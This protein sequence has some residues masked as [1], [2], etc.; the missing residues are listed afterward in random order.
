MIPPFSL[1]RVLLEAVQDFKNRV[2][3]LANQCSELKSL[4]DALNRQLKDM[5]SQLKIS[6]DKLKEAKLSVQ[7][8]KE[9]SKRLRFAIDRERI[10]A[11]EGEMDDKKKE[12]QIQLEAKDGPLAS[13][14]WFFLFCVFWLLIKRRT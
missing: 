8:E 2:A 4:N 9:E 3:P 6:E 12:V 5:Q 10:A 13:G 1:Q 7:T 11:K 14:F